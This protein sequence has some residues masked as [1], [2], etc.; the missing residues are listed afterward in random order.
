[1]NGYYYTEWIPNNSFLNVPQTIESVVVFGYV[2][3]EQ[4]LYSHQITFDSDDYVFVC[5]LLQVTK[6]VGE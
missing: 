1:V 3:V 5:I 2:R 6:N 4:S